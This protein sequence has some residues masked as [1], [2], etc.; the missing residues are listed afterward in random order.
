MKARGTSRF[1]PIGAFVRREEMI[2]RP[3]SIALA[4][5]LVFIPPFASFSSEES[6]LP[7]LASSDFEEGLA[8]G[9]QPNNPVH[10]RV[11]K[12]NGSLVYELTAPG[13]Q[14]KLRAPTSWS[15]LA[16]HDVT[17]F[18]F[19][20]RMRSAADPTNTYRDLCV[21]FHFQD[22]T[23]LGYV[24]FSARSDE[25]HNIIGLV[26][27]ADRVKINLE[28]P[29][30]TAFRLTDMN[31]HRFKVT[32]DAGTGR[33]E[34]FIDD[35]DTPIS[36]AI[37]KTLGHGLVGVGSFDDTGSFDDLMLWGIEDPRPTDGARDAD[38]LAERSSPLSG[39]ERTILDVCRAIVSTFRENPSTIWPG[40]NL[41]E[42]TYLVYLPKKWVLLFNP[43]GAVEG[44]GGCP[45]GWP[46]LRTKVLYHEGSYG[47]LV[48]QLAFDFEVGGVKTVAIG[49]PESSEG[50]PAALDVYLAG[51]IVHEAF[52][53]FQTDHFG[54]IP[55]QREERYPVLD[56][57]NTNLAVLEMR[58]LMDAV[59][60]A[61]AGARREVEDRLRMFVAVRGERWRVGGEFVGRHEQGL[62]IREGTA[63][64]VQTKALSLMTGARGLEGFSKVSLSGLL[65]E[66]F[67]TRFKG[68]SVTPDDM[69]RNRIYPVGA[70]LGSL[71]D[72]LGLDWK[73]L[74]QAAGPEFAF[75]TLIS[76]KIGPGEK[77]SDDLIAEAKKDYGYD[78]IAAAT[79]A[80][81]R[82][83]HEGYLRELKAFEG[84][85]LERLELE[86]SYRSISRGRNS[87]GRTWLI[88]N[89]SKSLGS[90]YLVYTL[91]NADLTLQ[92]HEAGVYEENDWDAKRKK[93]VFYVPMIQSASLDGRP[94]DLAVTISAAFRTL[95][96]TG[97]SL[98]LSITKPGKITR[99]GKTI[100]I[101]VA[102][103]IG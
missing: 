67:R 17:S 52:H 75:H 54:E 42:Q 90:R 49:L 99:T 57:E 88:D 43:A 56:R 18:R 69:P 15:V 58:I 8:T 95:E 82:E 98:N 60:R 83:Y 26:N 84:Q 30:K 16:A 53:Q 37:D 22:P 23:H 64:Y 59:S 47:D 102:E 6:R 11:T 94:I 62:E 73:P 71:S 10:W 4:A 66:D 21:F 12:Q 65:G 20:G 36:A 32:Y 72:F 31:W 76:G 46:D 24:H 45:E 92:L 40:Y 51:F 89:G 97:Q 35:M 2:R 79:D 63:E 7:L 91:K 41:A 80:S 34:A 29:G 68:E 1:T 3:V 103:T 14:G 44:F 100:V 19:E 28:P 48:G 61:Q 5:L 39:Y 93:V 74:A 78:K 86:F 96:I 70:A 101:K 25:F 9:W 38:P 33:L 50:F 85:P 55:W 87:L 27:G 13:E 77:R 81:I